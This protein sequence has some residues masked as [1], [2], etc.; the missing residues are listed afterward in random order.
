LGADF[1]KPIWL[2]PSEAGARKCQPL[3][4]PRNLGRKSSSWICYRRNRD[5]TKHHSWISGTRRHAH[6][7]HHFPYRNRAPPNGIDPVCT[8]C[9][10]CI[11]APCKVYW[12]LS[13]YY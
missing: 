3:R 6:S 4:Q 10:S 12:V 9:S 1:A 7:V 5:R 8:P 11:S 2:R 13:P